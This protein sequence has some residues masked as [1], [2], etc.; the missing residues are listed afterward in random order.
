MNRIHAKGSFE[1][2]EYKSAAAGIRPGMLVEVNSDGELVVN[3]TPT[4]ALG[5]ELLIALENPLAGEG[6]EDV[7]GAG[8][9][10]GVMNPHRGTTFRGLLNAD[11][12]VGLYDKLMSNGNGHFKKQAAPVSVLVITV[13]DPP[14]SSSHQLVLMRAV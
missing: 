1:Y 11:E 13:E 3:G 8:D 2:T 4:G 12:V 5:D 9:M 6:V 7:Y 14:S 10:I